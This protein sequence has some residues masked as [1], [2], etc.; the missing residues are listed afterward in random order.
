MGLVDGTARDS[1]FPFGEVAHGVEDERTSRNLLAAGGP[2]LVLEQAFFRSR[3]LDGFQSE[4]AQSLS[5]Q[6]EITG[7]AR[8]RRRTGHYTFKD[9]V[10]RPS[11]PPAEIF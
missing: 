6:I 5:R 4:A 2:L 8:G 1:R 3:L 7:R 11:W 10:E 9:E